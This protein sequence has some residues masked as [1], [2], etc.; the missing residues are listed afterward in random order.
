MKNSLFGQLEKT[1]QEMPSGTVMAVSDFYALANPKTV[2][3]MLNRLAEKGRIEKVLR[4]IFWK[5]DGVLAAPE[6][7]EV[8]KALARENNWELVPSGETAL[9]LMGVSP[10]RPKVWTYITNGTYRSYLYRDIRISFLHTKYQ[11]GGVM[12]EKTRLLVQCIRAYGPGKITE[13]TLRH[14]LR[15]CG[16]MNWTRIREECR[17]VSSRILK[18]LLT[19]S[20]MAA[21]N[22]TIK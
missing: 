18:I 17:S 4:S 12:S 10:D 13:E 1:V 19:M 3:K 6:P 20:T 21:I 11:L 2:S 15:C 5:P 8:A 16:E 14:L 9:H 7:N 22:N